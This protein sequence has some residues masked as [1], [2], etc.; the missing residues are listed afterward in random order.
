MPRNVDVFARGFGKKLLKRRKMMEAGK[1]E[2]AARTMGAETVKTNGKPK[3][4][5]PRTARGLTPMRG[6][7]Y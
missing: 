6:M 2:A 4:R 7:K 5:K 3:R 1:P